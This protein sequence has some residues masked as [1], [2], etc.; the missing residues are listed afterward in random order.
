[1]VQAQNEY[2]EKSST[3]L[4]PSVTPQRKSKVQQKAEIDEEI[5]SNSPPVD[6]KDTASTKESEKIKGMTSQQQ[7][8]MA[9]L[10]LLSSILPSSN[11]GET[12]NERS[13][14]SPQI[15]QYFFS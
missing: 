5:N 3:R 14:N 8:L 11:E 1:M 6:R 10:P 7:M 4:E 9:I 13:N 15:K 12:R 2:S